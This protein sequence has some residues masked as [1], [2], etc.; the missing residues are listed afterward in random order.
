[1]M[2]A[3]VVLSALVTMTSANAY[4]DTNPLTFSVYK[5]SDYPYCCYVSTGTVQVSSQLND[6]FH[7]GMA[8][9]NLLGN[10]GYR[11]EPILL[12]FVYAN[13]YSQTPWYSGGPPQQG[14][15]PYQGTIA[16]S[17]YFGDNIAARP[18][19]ST[20]PAFATV[21]SIQ[22]ANYSFGDVISFD[23]TSIFQHATR[24]GSPALG[25]RLAGSPT[26]SYLQSA[27][28]DSFALSP[29]LAVPEPSS[30]ALLLAGLGVVGVA[31]RR[32]R[33]TG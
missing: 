21:G 17:A 29:T 13:G 23:V 3:G 16:L 19:Y 33:R 14:T 15:L 7:R 12:S 27:T 22:L 28:F 26:V 20:T 6:L 24:A 25:F 32:R 5:D 2:R 18:D 8:E 31:A 11:G 30:Y 4:T 10:L 1:M 9:F